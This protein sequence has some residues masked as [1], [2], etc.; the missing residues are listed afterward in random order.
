MGAQ[1]SK[2]AGK[3]ETAAENPEEAAA[4]PSKANGQVNP[5]EG[6]S[7]TLPCLLVMRGVCSASSAGAPLPASSRIKPFLQPRERLCQ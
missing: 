6:M 4:S 2:T 1:F 3:G 5:R 7:V